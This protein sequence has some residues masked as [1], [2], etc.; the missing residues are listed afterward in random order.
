MGDTLFDKKRFSLM[1]N[2]LTIVFVLLIFLPIYAQDDETCGELSPQLVIGDVGRVTP[3]DANNM[4]NIPST[5]GD[6]VGQIPGE[7]EFIVLSGPVCSDGFTWWQVD[8]GGLIGWTVESIG[9]SYALEP[10]IPPT[11]TPVPTATPLPETRQTA[12]Y[13]IWSA[14]GSTLAVS[15][16]EGIWVYDATDWSVEPRLFSSP[17]WYTLRN[18]RSHLNLRNKRDPRMILNAD[19]SRLAMALCLEGRFGICRRGTIDVLNTVTGERIQRYNGR[20][21]Y[22]RGIAFLDDNQIVFHS[23]DEVVRFWSIS[24]NAVIDFFETNGQGLG[25]QASPDG[26]HLASLTEYMFGPGFY[27]H[28][29]E[30]DE[31]RSF[32]ANWDTSVVFSP[33]LRFVVWDTYYQHEGRLEVVE[34]LD[35]EHN[36][37]SFGSENRLIYEIPPI[38]LEDEAKIA[39]VY[40]FTGDNT[41]LV[42]GYRGGAIRMWDVFAQ[43]E[44]YWLPDA[45]DSAVNSIEFTLDGTVFAVVTND[46]R[47]IIWDAEIGEVIIEL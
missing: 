27:I 32:G 10:L 30:S 35:E 12:D 41:R 11:P 3:G 47:V 46:D 2:P 28:N 33:D 14:D 20:A 42:I 43:E 31:G 44:I 29:V 19:G 16:D 18:R 4:R 40:G 36:F 17:D 39:Q 34:V 7:A 37:F 1:K 8:Y 23:A 21:G 22:I 5:G 25:L 13:A 9:D 26:V 38:D 45:Y 6:R 24:R 15:S